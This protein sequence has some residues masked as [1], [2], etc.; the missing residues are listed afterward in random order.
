M[1]RYRDA[2]IKQV[3]KRGPR[4]GS[5][6]GGSGEYAALE[7]LREPQQRHGVSIWVL[8]LGRHKYALSAHLQRY[9]VWIDGGDRYLFPADEIGGTRQLV[10]IADRAGVAPE[11]VEVD[12]GRGVR[13]V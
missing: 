3:G 11:E 6:R 4:P 2:A 7:D 8:R 10:F 1:C 12:K 9:Q 5:W 13:T